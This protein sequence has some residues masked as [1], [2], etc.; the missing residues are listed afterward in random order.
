MIFLIFE[1]MIFREKSKKELRR[2]ESCPM[3]SSFL[4]LCAWRRTSLT[5]VSPESAR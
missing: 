3:P 2:S 1:E 4:V 5:G